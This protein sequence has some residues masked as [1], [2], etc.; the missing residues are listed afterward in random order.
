MGREG[1]ALRGFSVQQAIAYYY[2]KG[3]VAPDCGWE[4]VRGSRGRHPKR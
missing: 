1:A 3:G 4:E 2:E